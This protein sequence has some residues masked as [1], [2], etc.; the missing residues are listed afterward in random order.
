MNRDRAKV[1]TTAGPAASIHCAAWIFGAFLQTRYHAAV[2]R[3]RELVERFRTSEL[4][5][6]RK[7]TMRDEN[8]ICRRRDPVS[9]T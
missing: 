8:W 1:P 2:E 6:S 5:G 4:S 3:Y 9:R 7:A